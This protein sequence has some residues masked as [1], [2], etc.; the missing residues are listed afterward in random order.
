MVLLGLLFM[1]VVV[2]R[3]AT[4]LWFET[5]ATSCKKCFFFF[6]LPSF[7]NFFPSCGVLRGLFF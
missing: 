3:L 2:C 5:L 4:E 6:S 7:L 1:S